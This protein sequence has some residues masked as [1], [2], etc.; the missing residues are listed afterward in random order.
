M[1]TNRT[2]SDERKQTSGETAGRGRRQA[3]APRGAVLLAF[4]I[5]WAAITGYYIGLSSPM[6]PEVVEA[7]PVISAV[8]IEL[9][10]EDGTVVVPAT[11]Y[12]DIGD[13]ATSQNHD[14]TTQLTSLK[15]AP[16]DLRGAVHVNPLDKEASLATRSELRAFNGA[17]PTVPHRVDQMTSQSCIACHGEGIKSATLRAAKMPH[18]FYANCTQCHVEQQ[19]QQFEATMVVENNFNGLAAPRAGARAFANAPPVVPHTTWLRG[20]CLSCHGRTARPGMETTHPWRDNCLQC[21]VSS[22]KL[23]QTRLPATPNF[24][25]PPTIEDT[26]E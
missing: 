11:S 26:D 1:A 19:L 23:D 21:H 17:P 12:A 8:H 7:D 13:L 9:P 25:P 16:Y 10:P 2:S 6:N 20:D 24:L 22:S 3:T 14:W 18:P 15:Q 4:G 5:I